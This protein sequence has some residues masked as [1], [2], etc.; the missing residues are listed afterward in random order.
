MKPTLLQDLFGCLGLLATATCFSA[1]DMLS[2]RH[3]FDCWAQQPLEDVHVLKRFII[4]HHTSNLG[5]GT[6]ASALPSLQAAKACT[7]D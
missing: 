1:A 2:T 3:T 4:L 5:F 7:A 6:Q